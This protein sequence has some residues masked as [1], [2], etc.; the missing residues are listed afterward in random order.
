MMES[1]L[2]YPIESGPS[3]FNPLRN[4]SK[5]WEQGQSRASLEATSEKEVLALP[6]RETVYESTNQWMPQIPGRR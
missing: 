4:T 2:S 5:I 6:I 1:T 3:T